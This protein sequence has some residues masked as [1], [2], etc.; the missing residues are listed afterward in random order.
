MNIREKLEAAAKAETQAI[1]AG[2]DEEIL[3]Y[4]QERNYYFDQVKLAIRSTGAEVTDG[5]IQKW[6]NHYKDK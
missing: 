4:A 2:S 1:Q 5:Q 6:A 3:L